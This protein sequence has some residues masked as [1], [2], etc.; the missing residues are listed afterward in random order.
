MS[1]AINP[2][3]TWSESDSDHFIDYGAYFVPEREVQIDTICSVI[4]QPEGLVHI[5]EL[6][7]GEGLLS[8]ALAERF[9]TAVVHALDG[10]KTMLEATARRLQPFGDRFDTQLFDI[11]SHEWREWSWPLHAVVSSLA[12]H[13]LDGPG[14]ARLFADMS[15]ALAPGGVLVICD[16]VESA[17]KQGK[18]VYARHWDDGV[19][20]RAME[21]DGN[22]DKFELFKDDR[23]NY[24][25]DPEPDPV[26]Q[27][28]QL[29]SQLTWMEAAGLTRVD[30]HWLKAGHAI[31]SGRKSKPPSPRSSP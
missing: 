3:E 12:V 15:A 26:D 22:L 21:L 25:S 23:W 8:A 6:C 17:S 7:C 30:V 20:H 5:A 31:F 4:P 18:E 27:P 1:K 29:F 9:P 28:S 16:L 2:G 14:K 11:S 13:H 10:S 19:R 24:Y